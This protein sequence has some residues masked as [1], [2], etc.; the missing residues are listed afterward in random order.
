M[1]KEDRF[2]SVFLSENRD[3]GVLLSFYPCS[4]VLVHVGTVDGSTNYEM[5]E[6][7]CLNVPKSSIEPRNGK[8]CFKLSKSGSN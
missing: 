2:L 7:R 5:L 8:P 4:A 1:V 3:M 6:S